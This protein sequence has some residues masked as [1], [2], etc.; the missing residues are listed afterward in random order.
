MVPGP[1][2]GQCYLP[3]CVAEP[4]GCP[5]LPQRLN[6]GRTL[7]GSAWASASPK[8][9]KPP[10]CSPARR[11]T[12]PHRQASHTLEP[13]PR[14]G[15][16]PRAPCPVPPC[17]LGEAW[18]KTWGKTRASPWLQAPS[19]PSVLSTHRRAGS[20]TL[21]PSQPDSWPGPGEQEATLG[22]SAGVPGGREA[23]RAASLRDLL[24]PRLSLGVTGWAGTKQ[25]RGQRW[26]VRRNLGLHHPSPKARVRVTSQH[27]DAPEPPH[28]HSQAPGALRGWAPTLRTQRK[29]QVGWTAHACSTSALRAAASVPG[30]RQAGAGAPGTRGLQQ[31]RDGLRLPGKLSGVSC[32]PTQGPRWSGQRT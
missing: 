24:D 2:A 20:L 6:A 14:L 17:G 5:Q 9:K 1:S 23:V 16:P 15:R 32:V 30:Q 27:P 10:Y 31:L 26:G 8:P 21:H 13:G 25:L 11:P 18:G 28:R 12:W 7:A 3:R 4:R 29:P 19:G 22:S